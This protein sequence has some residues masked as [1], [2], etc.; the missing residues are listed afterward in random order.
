VQVTDRGGRDVVPWLIALAG[1][2][3]MTVVCT[4]PLIAR[5][6]SVVPHDPGDPLLSTWILWWNAHTTPLTSQWWDAPAFWPLRG[7]LALSEHL[8]G[9]SVLATPMQWLGAS[10]V[11]AYNTV[12]LLSFPLSALATHALAY[13][14][15]ARHDASAIAG[16]AFGF[17]PYRLSHISHVQMLWVFW[18]PLA[19]LALHRYARDGGASWLLLFAAMWI[20]LALSN[21]YLMLFF[22]FLL[23]LWSAWFLTCRGQRHRLVRVAAAWGVATIALLPIVVVYMHLNGRFAFERR[24]DEIRI[25]SAR[26][27]SL[28][29]ASPLVAA[30]ALFPPVGNAEQQLFPGVTVL[31][32]VAIAAVVAF[33]RGATKAWR[34]SWWSA[35]FA[36]IAVAA[37]GLAAL[38]PVTGPWRFAIG[39]VTILSVSTATKPLTVAV[40]CALLAMAVG[41][42]RANTWTGRS[43]FA[44]YVLGTI[45]MYIF[46]FGPE[47]AL[48]GVPFWYRAPYAWLLE[49]PGFSNVRVPARFALLA[50]LSLAIAAAIAFA[51]IRTLLP[52]RTRTAA[53]LL[54][55]AGACADGWMHG[56]VLADLPPRSP[57]LEAV[58]EGAVVELPL[59]DVAGDIAAMYRSIYHHRPVVNG[60]SGFQ[61][62]HY[63]ILAEAFSEHEGDLSSAIAGGLPFTVVEGG[64]LTVLPPIDRVDEP[65]VGAPVAI[66]SV[67]V[68]GRAIDA[69]AVSDDNRLSRWLSATPQRG[70]ESITVDLSAVRRI[71]GIVLS[72]GAFVQD[73]P[74]ALQIETSEDSREW[75]TVWSGRGAARAVAG[76]LKDPAMVPLS[77]TF[78]PA[79]A[80]WIRL[81]QLGRHSIAPWSIAELRV[82]GK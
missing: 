30:S 10:P 73:Y 82:Y 68:D 1:Y 60:Y 40:W 34:R 46:S 36:A 41:A 31:A 19:L 53:A 15:T 35:G 29:S 48:F 43:V 28:L 32:L 63:A 14:L 24:Y 8:L 17:N 22:P 16:L 7:T 52:E 80:R 71:D 27:G 51:R 13:E 67:V 23:A 44:F 62:I 49:L 37:V 81:R 57:V 20:G 56:L 33:Q 79:S 21:S 11:A 74:R 61:P 75:T 47:P 78:A 4:W 59:G 26:I 77:F 66:Q 5:L 12:F 69:S 54:V 18:M 70:S 45:V 6:A 39:R 3:A 58:H 50:V 9:L 72:Q 2:A 38:L 25:F 64:R 55:V 65:P 76:A 42:R